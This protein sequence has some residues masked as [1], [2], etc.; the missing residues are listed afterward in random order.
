MSAN[1]AEFFIIFEPLFDGFLI[2]IFNLFVI[3]NEKV[4]L[5]LLGTGF[6]MKNGIHKDGRIVNLPLPNCK[7]IVFREKG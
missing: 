2:P 6:L 4:L 5:N 1:C 7:E 3:K